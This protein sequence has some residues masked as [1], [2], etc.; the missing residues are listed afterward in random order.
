MIRNMETQHV[1]ITNDIEFSLSDVA[2]PIIMA[3]NVHHNPS[4]VLSYALQG[5]NL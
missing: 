5:P 2:S 3:I 4:T 1:N